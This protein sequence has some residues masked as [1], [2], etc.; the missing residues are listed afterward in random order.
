MGFCLQFSVVNFLCIRYS[1]L[2]LHY[3]Q[4]VIKIIESLKYCDYI[5]G[6]GVSIG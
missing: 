3:F 4:K 6:L 2:K 5:Y 1:S